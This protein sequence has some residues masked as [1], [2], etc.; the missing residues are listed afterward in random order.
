[1]TVNASP[2]TLLTVYRRDERPL[3]DDKVEEVHEVKQDKKKV[4]S[5]RPWFAFDGMAEMWM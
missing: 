1:V 2:M 4:A 3:K 5:A